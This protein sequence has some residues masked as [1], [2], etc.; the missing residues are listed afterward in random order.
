MATYL[1]IGAYLL[2]GMTAFFIAGGVKNTFRSG[3][4]SAVIF[5]ILGLLDSQVKTELRSLLN[6]IAVRY[7]VRPRYIYDLLVRSKVSHPLTSGEVEKMVNAYLK[8]KDRVALPN[9]LLGS[10]YYQFSL[11]SPP[12][13][14]QIRWHEAINALNELDSEEFESTSYDLLVSLASPH[15]V[16]INDLDDRRMEALIS[17]LSGISSHITTKLG[18]DD[19]RILITV[20]RLEGNEQP[21]ALRPP[22]ISAA[23]REEANG[24]T[25]LRDD[26]S[27]QVFSK[28]PAAVMQS[29]TKDLDTLLPA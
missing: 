5:L 6:R 16:K 8:S 27:L 29:M 20:N 12:E 1:K 26:H 9:I 13:T 11:A 15:I 14:F 28:D 22:S 4:I 25:V 24:A 10:N 2:V 18:H 7:I 17:L 23:K 21:K 3:I 19:S